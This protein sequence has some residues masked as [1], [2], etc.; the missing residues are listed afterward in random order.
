MAIDSASLKQSAAEAAA[1]RITNGMVVGLGTGS[2]ADWAT[3]YLGA[4]SLEIT[5]IPT[6]EATAR[7]ASELGLNL[8]DLSDVET[9]DVLIDG[10]DECTRDAQMIKGGGGALLREK[11][12]ATIAKDRLYVMDDSKVVEQLGTFPLPVEVNR[13]GAELVERVLAGEGLEPRRRQSGTGEDFV[14]DNG[15]FILDCHGGPWKNPREI[16]VFLRSVVGVVETGFFL[17][18]ATE[19]FVAS[20]DGVSHHV[21]PRG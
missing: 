13:F 5:C 4:R 17:D 14:T 8:A 20:G 2:T 18:V 19:I 15:H 1:Q 11:L 3:R 16:E 6:S 7:L 12:V 21:S 9:I 10:A